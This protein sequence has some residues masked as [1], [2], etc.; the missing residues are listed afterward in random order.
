MQ[1]LTANT[2]AKVK[3]FA[4]EKFAAIKD[5]FRAPAFAYAA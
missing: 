1:F 3:A 5:A 4:S 2:F